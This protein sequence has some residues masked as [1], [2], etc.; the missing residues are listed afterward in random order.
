[1]AVFDQ[2][3]SGNKYVAGFD[4]FNEPL[5]SWK[6]IMSMIYEVLPGHQDKNELA[7]MYER[8]Y[9]KYQAADADNIMMFEPA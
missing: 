8:L 2:R 4:P 1:L 9:E 7:P 3:L 5:P 6:G